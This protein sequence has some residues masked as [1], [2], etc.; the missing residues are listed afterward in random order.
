MGEVPAPGSRRL[1]PKVIALL[2]KLAHMPSREMVFCLDILLEVAADLRTQFRPRR[3]LPMV[4]FSKQWKRIACQLSKAEAALGNREPGRV[5]LFDV[6]VRGRLYKQTART[7]D[8]RLLELLTAEGKSSLAAYGDLITALRHLA[9]AAGSI[10]AAR[11]N[12]PKLQMGGRAWTEKHAF[13]ADVYHAIICAGGKLGT[14]R[15]DGGSFYQF[16]DEL[17]PYSRIDPPA[18]S[19]VLERIKRDVDS[20]FAKRAS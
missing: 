18:G 7:A 16:L 3:A 8:V 19:R 15:T 2:A 17:K 11:A 1:P 12:R 9:E 20:N 14:D 10:V 13:A 5:M 4:A 6:I